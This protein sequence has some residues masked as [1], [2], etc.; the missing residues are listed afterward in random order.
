MERR[1]AAGRLAS[2]GCSGPGLKGIRYAGTGEESCL[3]G[4]LAEERSGGGLTGVGMAEAGFNVAG[5]SS[6][7]AAL[8]GA[9]SLCIPV[10]CDGVSISMGVLPARMLTLGRASRRMRQRKQR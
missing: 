3:D 4:S 6:S 5:K 7:V 10:R 9:A 8:R 1:K 2:L